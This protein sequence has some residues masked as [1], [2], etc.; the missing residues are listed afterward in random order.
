[1]YGAETAAGIAGRPQSPFVGLA[2]Q[3]GF[4][5]RECQVA[6]ASG[7]LPAIV[8]VAELRRRHAGPTMTGQQALVRMR[9]LELRGRLLD[10]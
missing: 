7:R 4:S 5:V 8:A 2:K 1:M 6:A 9:L 3:S 10:G